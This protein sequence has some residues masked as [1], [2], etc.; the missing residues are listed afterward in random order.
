MQVVDAGLER[1]G[2]A[3]KVVLARAQEDELGLPDGPE[4]QIEGER[5][6]QA[7]TAAAAAP[8]AIQG[9]ASERS[10]IEP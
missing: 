7:A 3:D 2:E 5:E 10:D 8:M 4:L 1:D 6:D 9:A